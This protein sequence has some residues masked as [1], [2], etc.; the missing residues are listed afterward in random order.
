MRKNLN[1]PLPPLHC[2][3]FRQVHGEDSSAM[4]E[5]DSDDDENDERDVITE[6]DDTDND[7]KPGEKI[8][9]AGF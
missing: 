9:T 8:T 1:F 7:W 3:H 5:E 4:T 6:I 2:R